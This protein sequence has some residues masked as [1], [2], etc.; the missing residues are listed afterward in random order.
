MSEGTTT[1]NDPG[2][3]ALSAAAYRLL[4]LA[5]PARFRGEYGTHMAQAFRDCCLRAMRLDGPPG[6]LR[7]WS[8]TLADWLKSVIEQHLLKGVHMSKARFIRISGW[9]LILGAAALLLATVAAAAVSPASS[10]YD[11]RYR[12]TDSFFQAVQGILFPTAVVLITV[13]LAGLYVRY[14]AESG[15]L[16]RLGLTL[17][18]LGGVATFALMLSLFM[19]ENGNPLWSAMMLSIAVMFGGLA[20]FGIDTLGSRVLPR[21][22]Y[23]PILAGFGFPTVVITSLVYEAIT[24]RS[25]EMSDIIT[26]AIFLVTALA[27]LALGQILRSEVVE[28]PIPA[29]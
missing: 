10:Q 29:N 19:S 20:L 21:R 1:R 6:M 25:L 26:A 9:A 15:R 12:P 13:G 4:L 7:L 17:G 8:L 23:L 3:V 14:S 28:A 5:Y 2:L 16:G 11:A 24:G 18:I 27:L 22:G